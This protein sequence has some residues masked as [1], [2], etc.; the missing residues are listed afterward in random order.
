M[1]CGAVQKTRD[2]WKPHWAVVQLKLK[3]TEYVEKKK[4]SLCLL[5]TVL[6]TQ[7]GEGGKH[8]QMQDEVKVSGDLEFCFVFFVVVGA[9]VLLWHCWS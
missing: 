2:T 8:K 6:E 1:D 4:K 7:T 5:L 9:L 3:S